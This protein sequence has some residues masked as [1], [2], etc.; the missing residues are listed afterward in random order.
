[1]NANTGNWTPATLDEIKVYILEEVQAM[2]ANLGQFWEL[3]KV[4]PQK[5]QEKEYGEMG[6]G[7]W[8]VGLIGQ[9]VI[10]Y[11]DIEEGFNLSTYSTYGEIDQYNCEQDQ[12]SQI[13]RK[14][15]STQLD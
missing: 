4:N 10:W 13:I 15:F 1:M 9:T 3:V 8:V 7:F 14:L 6:G 11:N 2:S 5:W 12:L